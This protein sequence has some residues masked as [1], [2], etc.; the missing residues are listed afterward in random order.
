MHLSTFIIFLA[1][2]GNSFVMASP[3]LRSGEICFSILEPLHNMARPSEFAKSVDDSLHKR[4]LHANFVIDA[5]VEKREEKSID[6][7]AA[8]GV[9]ERDE[10]S[11]DAD[12]AYGF[13]E[14]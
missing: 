11:I 8:Y 9:Y 10:A 6:A 2:A 14:D 13:Y 7:D 4:T 12:A 5:V 3:T 1:A